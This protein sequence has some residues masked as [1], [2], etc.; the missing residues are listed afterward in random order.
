MHVYTD[1]QTYI[2]QCTYYK[3]I[4]VNNFCNVSLTLTKKYIFELCGSRI[5]RVLISILNSLYNHGQL[6]NAIF[7]KKI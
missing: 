5:V 6:A 1:I 7:S 3:I 4:I 2:L